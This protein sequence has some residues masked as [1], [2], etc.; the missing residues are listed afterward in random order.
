[1]EEVREVT[2]MARR[3][4]AILPLQPELD[5]N[6]LAVE[7]ATWEWTGPR[8]G[9]SATMT[10]T[11]DSVNDTI[12]T[13]LGG[14]RMSAVPNIVP[15][16]DLRQDASGIVKRAAVTGDP[17]FITQRGRATAVMVSTQTYE[18][19]LHELEILRALALGEAE[20][21]AGIGHDA[22]TVFAEADEL[23]SGP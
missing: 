17:V 12:N 18:R 15:I 23:L 19:T 8:E 4:A 9:V 14:T 6:Y 22:V 7:G 11:D 3:I 10:A 20:I 13:I 2:R 16:S 21:E 1:M 5:A